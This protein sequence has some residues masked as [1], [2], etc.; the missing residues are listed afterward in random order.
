MTKQ[1][2]IVVD[3][4][5]ETGAMRAAKLMAEKVAWQEE[6]YKDVPPLIPSRQYRRWVGA[7]T[8]DR[9][10]AMLKAK[11]IRER[12]QKKPVAAQPKVLEAN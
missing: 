5:V 11:Q 7:Y 10:S 4:V 1:P 2:K 9:Q 12:R 8:L 3:E 6:Y